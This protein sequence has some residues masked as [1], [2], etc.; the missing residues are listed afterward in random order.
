MNT[1]R[2]K[3]LARTLALLALLLCCAGAAAQTPAPV[4]GVIVVDTSASVESLSGP[5]GKKFLEAFGRFAQAGD[6]FAVIRVSTYASIHLE[7]TEDAGMVAKKVSELFKDK[8]PQATSLYDGCALALKKALGSR[9]GRRFILVLS[10]GVDTVSELPLKEVQR[11]LH[12][13][14]V[15]LFAVEVGQSQHVGGSDG[16]FRNLEALAKA[17]G[18]AAFR[19]KKKGDYDAIFE[20]VREALAR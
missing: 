11:L 13:G 9:H 19:L 16:G 15:K 6:E 17:S 8:E 1:R 14:G 18:G 4:G 2:A 12:E 3:H 20:N 5:E 10:D 7:P